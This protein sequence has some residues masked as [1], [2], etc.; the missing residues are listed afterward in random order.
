MGSLRAS[1]SEEQGWRVMTG[2]RVVTR[3]REQVR[4]MRME[5]EVDDKRVFGWCYEGEVSYFG[6][7]VWD[8]GGIANNCIAK[9]VEQN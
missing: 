3:R 1:G 5:L 4:R 7:G 2:M 6:K 9:K 8:I